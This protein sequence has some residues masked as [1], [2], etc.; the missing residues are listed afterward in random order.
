MIRDSRTKESSA[1]LGFSQEELESYQVQ[2]ANFLAE[3]RHEGGAQKRR[4][5]VKAAATQP[6]QA[7]LDWL[8]AVEHG[9]RWATGKTYSSFDNQKLLDTPVGSDGLVH[10]PDGLLRTTTSCPPLLVISSDQHTIQTCG[11]SF[12]KFKLGL[13]FGD[14]AHKLKKLTRS[15]TI[16]KP[17]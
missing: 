5:L 15:P 7:T 8:R 12:L 16:E 2:V 6:R 3:S 13:E 1:G 11:A 4:K 14:P 17:F 9:M 10:F